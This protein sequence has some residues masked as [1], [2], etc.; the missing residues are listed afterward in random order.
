M[1]AQNSAAKPAAFAKFGAYYTYKLKFLRPNIIMNSILALLSY[2][3]AFGL[4]IPLCMASENLSH[5]RYEEIRNT[6]MAYDEALR[7]A[8]LEYQRWNSIA[9]AGAVIGIICLAML[10]A[11]T[12]VTTVRCFR[13]LYDRNYVD[14]DYSLPINS[15]TRFCADTLATLTATIVPHFLGVIIGILL[16]NAADLEVLIPKRDDLLNLIPQYMFVGIFAC[17][18]LVGLTMLMLSFCGKKA[19]ACIYP[20]LINFAIPMIHVLCIYI[21]E[22]NTYGGYFDIDLTGC[23]QIGITSPLGM[24]LAAFV[25]LITDILPDWLPLFSPQYGIPTL[26]VTLAFFAAAYFIMKIRR[27]E[28]VG[29]PY[30]FG[31]MN[32]VIPGIVILAVTMLLSWQM[33][34]VVKSGDSPFGWLIIMVVFTFILYVVMDLISGTAFRK[35]YLTAAKWAG[36]VAVSVGITALLFYSNGFGAAYYVPNANNVAAVSVAVN[37]MNDMSFHFDAAEAEVINATIEAHAAIPKDGSA[38]GG[39]FIDITYSMKNGSTFTRQYFLSDEYIEQFLK[40]VVTPASF[41]HNVARSLEGAMDDGLSEIKYITVG[42]TGGGGEFRIN[43]LTAEQLAESLKQDCADVDYD[44][45]FNSRGTYS[46]GLYVE[47]YSTDISV[48]SYIEMYSWMHNTISL[49]GQYGVQINADFDTTPYKSAYII[50][51]NTEE[52]W[53][54]LHISIEDIVGIC[55]GKTSS[56]DGDTERDFT[57]FDGYSFAKVDMSDSRVTELIDN[58]TASSVGAN[59][60]KYELLLGT[61]EDYDDYSRFT[62]EMSEIYFPEEYNDIA[63]ALYMDYVD[64][65]TLSV[66]ETRSDVTIMVI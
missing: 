66:A 22:S 65:K 10:A 5:V 6:S 55:D 2:P 8:A 23:F 12:L 24:V 14:M 41:Y 51:Y 61:W 33:F 3:L 50:K 46:F 43:G 34:S 7:L 4:M 63:E 15:S 26:L 18:M 20:V 9:S 38:D 40:K 52:G 45:A 13:Y 53:E 56:K 59:G 60:L 21:V 57:Y 32:Y 49:L 35:F 19:E 30:V 54:L 17:I 1:T 37:N 47:M 31:A 28:R 39:K 25:P 42:E 64:P 44:K 62:W 16:E 29:S 58:M 48:N 36:S 11:F 27:N